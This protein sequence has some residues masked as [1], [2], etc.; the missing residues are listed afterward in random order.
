MRI[1][2]TGAHGQLGSE[3][4]KVLAGETLILADRPDFELTD[5]SLTRQIV[6]QRPQVI[7]HTA[8]NTDVDG[9]E[10]DPNAAF[11]V[12]AEGSR[13]VAQA[14]AAI[15]AYLV[16]LSTDYVFEGT[17]STPY[18]EN[19]PTNPLNAYGRS[20]LQGE[21]EVI[22]VGRNTL[23]VRTSWLYGV[24]GKNFVKTILRSAATQAEVRVVED[25][26]G[27]PTYARELAEVIAGLI[28]Q[29]IRGIVHAGG[30]GGCS[31]HEFAGAVLEEAQI[32]CK[33][34]PIATADSRRLARRPRYSVLSA[35]R[36]HDYG[37]RLSPWRNALKRF[38]EDYA[39]VDHRAESAQG[40]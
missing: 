28:R 37:L 7:I 20:K 5:P 11:S 10:G 3:L 29:G 32:R 14:A 8:A 34:V 39:A 19:D 4:Q 21:H 17:Q 36:L 23:I 22:T 25:Q 9:C 40:R 30:E 6:D 18:T 24:H 1:L 13:L 31:W 35:T 38:M 2:I 27:S 33:N 16:Y 26:W 15:G 12:N